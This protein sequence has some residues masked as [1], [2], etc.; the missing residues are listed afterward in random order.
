MQANLKR[1][2]GSVERLSA[3]VESM[4]QNNVSCRRNLMVFR[5]RM[6]AAEGKVAAMQDS[7][8]RALDLLAD[9]EADARR[10]TEIFRATAEGRSAE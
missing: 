9:A 8:T 5:A 7:L 6:D 4:H 10:A 3:A 1:M 2:V